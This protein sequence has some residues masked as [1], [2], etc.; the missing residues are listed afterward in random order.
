MPD[1]FLVEERSDGA[2][3]AGQVSQPVQACKSGLVDLSKQTAPAYFLGENLMFVVVIFFGHLQ[4]LRF[5]VVKKFWSCS[6]P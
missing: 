4:L 6:N 3:E 2:T 5:V 1:D